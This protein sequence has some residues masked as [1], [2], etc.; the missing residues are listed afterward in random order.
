[1][2]NQKLTKSLLHTTDKYIDTLAKWG[3]NTIF[4]FINLLPRD[5]DD[6]TSVIDNFSLINIKDKNTAI[7]ELLSIDS[8]KTA[9]WMILV[10]AVFGDKNG[11]M[12]EWV[13]FNQRYIQNELKKY[14]GKKIIISWKVK[15]N[16]WKVTFNSPDF[17]GDLSKSWWEVIP[18]YSDQNY[19]PGSWIWSKM[20]YM[21]S[22]IKDIVDDLPISIIK[23]YNF[24]SRATAIEKLHFPW[25]RHD[26]ELAQNRLAYDE[27][28]SIHYKSIS[29]KYI[30]REKTTWNSPS[31]PLNPDFVKE[32]IQDL[33]F[34]LTDHQKIALFQILKDIEKPYQM[35]RLL[36]WDVG[37][38]KT[39]VRAI[40]TIHTI[41]ESEKLW[42][43]LQ[44]R[45]LAPTEVLSRQHFNWLSELFD[46]YHLNSSLLVG[47][48]T[49]KQKEDIKQQLKSWNINI[50][51]W[52]HRL[53]QDDV[54][55]DNLWLVIIDE[56]HR[57]WVA[58]RET[59]ELYSNNW[60]YPHSLNMTATPIPRTLALTLYGDQ[61]L[62]IIREYPKGRKEIYTKVISTLEQREQ[63]ELFIRSQISSG[64]QVF[65]ISPL[66]EESEKLDIA[67]ATKIYESLV[68]IFS[69]YN[70][71]LLHWKMKASEKEE[72]MKD[73][74]DNKIQILS[75]T[76]VVE[77]WVDV[78]NATI[79]CIEWRERF[80]LSQL[81][82]FRWRVGRWSYQS[83]CYLFPTTWQKTDRLKAM[84]RTNDWFELSEIDLEIRWPW[85]VYGFRQ[86]WEI[87][88]KIADIQDLELVSQIRGDIEELFNDE[89]IEN[90]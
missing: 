86:S 83:Y 80:G 61:D 2:L 77:V 48:T 33:S 13:W 87:E 41:L 22:Y 70:V 43:K 89:N 55:F 57:F 5:I 75:S 76:S 6:R 84:E 82:Q 45:I 28:F 25:S 23:K 67:N 42:N 29:S 58:Q 47:S 1:M 46:K 38:W 32:I 20:K 54:I 16:Y 39:I 63:I 11:L 10:K 88:L 74:E 65:W 60:V 79:M 8:N 4:D 36:E 51:I 69:P 18:I 27:L 9:R 81:H 34:E 44:V 26:Y 35:Q 14:I 40:A 66:V 78:P 73:F 3:I 49:K 50:I 21:R 72:I 19:I 56:Q 7:V 24:I 62:S 90:K 30:K 68:D 17:D 31:I 71:W 52:T 37:T 85:E 59:L 64:R 53:L 12:A 15:Y